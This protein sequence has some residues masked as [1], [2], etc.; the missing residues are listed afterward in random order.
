MK[1]LVIGLFDEMMDPAIVS[2]HGSETSEMSAHAADHTGNTGNSLKEETSGD[3]FDFGHFL[4][5]IPG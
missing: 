1:S 3:P 4:W 2:L 5:V